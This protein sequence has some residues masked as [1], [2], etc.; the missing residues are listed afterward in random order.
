MNGFQLLHER[1]SETAARQG[2]ARFIVVIAKIVEALAA[3]FFGLA[4]A[5]AID[6]KHHQNDG[7][8]DSEIFFRAAMRDEKHELEPDGSRDDH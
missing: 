1:R 6:R 7:W 5:Y 3:G 8:R 2:S 4:G